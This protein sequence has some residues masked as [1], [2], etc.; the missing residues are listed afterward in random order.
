MVVSMRV[1]ALSA[2]WWALSAMACGQITHEPM[3]TGEV[4]EPDADCVSVPQLNQDGVVRHVSSEEATAGCREFGPQGCSECC[5]PRSENTDCLVLD[6][7][8]E[9]LTGSPCEATCPSCARCSVEDEASL[10]DLAGSVQCDCSIF[11]GSLGFDPDVPCDRD[12]YYLESAASS[13][14]H[15]VCRE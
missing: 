13:C 8:G 10:Y 2:A 5:Y 14:P 11:G 9:R 1:L 6:P 3:G 7:A 15:K 4:F 12:C